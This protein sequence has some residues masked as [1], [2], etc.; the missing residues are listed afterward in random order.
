MT[1]RLVAGG[2][3][4]AAAGLVAAGIALG[5]GTSA[6]DPVSLTLNYNCPFPL[7]GTQPIKVVINT[8][9]PKTT[10]VGQQNPAFDIEAITTVPE[11]ATQGLTLVGAKTVEG[12]AVSSAEVA[13]PEA[14]LPVNV[15]ITVEK[16]PIPASGAFDVR[17]TGQTP[18]LTFSKAGPAK[19]TV[20][21]LKLTLT[22]RTADGSETGLGTFDSVCTLAPGQNNEL[23]TIEILPGDSNPPTSTTT[24]VPPTTTT[25]TT[26]TQ[27][28]PTTTTTPPNNGVRVSYD[29]KGVS[30]LKG[31]LT[32]PV[33]LSGTFDANA[34]LAKGVYTGDLKLNRTSG[35]FK[36]FGFLESKADIEFVP[37]GQA[38]G[39]VATGAITFNGKLTVKLPKVSLFGI[40][41]SQEPTCQTV[42]P[43]DISLKSVGNFDVL[44]GGK[45]AGTYGLSAVQGCGGLNDF[46]SPFVQGNGHTIDMDLTIKQ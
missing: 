3:A 18:P 26:T 45:I 16:T 11:T 40:P 43:S 5:S 1:R 37:V 7:I 21:G 41:I 12:S 19:I 44:K 28:P 38:S 29:L 27:Q 14:T 6:A 15:P 35:T 8:D 32:G 33:P 13:A 2:A 39:T 4:F 22:P 36:I 24:T 25:T 31:M 10:K 20:N 9:I 46:I 42:T 30:N 23:A 34:D 17:A